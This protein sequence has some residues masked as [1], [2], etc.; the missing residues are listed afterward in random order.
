MAC[1]TDALRRQSVQ[2]RQYA[3]D[4]F[5]RLMADNG[6]T[7]L[8]SR[9]R[10]IWDKAA[11]ESCFS[12]LKTERVARNVDRTRDEAKADVFGDIEAFLKSLKPP[13]APQ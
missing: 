9:S 1:T 13:A 10:N 2:R 11:M 3:K 6:V 8:M 4:Q 12:S 7:C 5:Q